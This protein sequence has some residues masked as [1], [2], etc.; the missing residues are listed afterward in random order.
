MTA[1]GLAIWVLSGV[2]FFLVPL[3]Q[4]VSL[5][6][7]EMHFS[8]RLLIGIATWCKEHVILYVA[9]CI[10]GLWLLMWCKHRFGE[11]RVSAVLL[12]ALGSSAGFLA[13]TLLYFFIPK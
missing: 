12:V 5:S 10:V 8:S 1:Y 11:E 9:L 4:P 3:M 13:V 2:I 6:P 7:S